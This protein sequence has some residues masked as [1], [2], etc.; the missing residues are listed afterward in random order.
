MNLNL[1]NRFYQLVVHCVASGFKYFLGEALLPIG[2]VTILYR[3]SHS[4]HSIR[5]V[6]SQPQNMLYSLE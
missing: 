6:I 3:E 1:E 5:L 4:T 2:R